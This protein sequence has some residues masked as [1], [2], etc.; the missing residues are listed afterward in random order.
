MNQQRMKQ[1]IMNQL[2]MN[3]ALIA[4]W[5]SFSSQEKRIL[6]T[7]AVVTLCLIFY[8]FAW[9]PVQHGRERLAKV[10]PEQQAKLLL[11]R[12]QAA[13]IERLRSLYKA[14]GASTGALKA[15]IQVSAKMQGL[16]PSYNEASASNISAKNADKQLAI[17]L[18]QVSFDSWLKWVES[19][20]SQNHVRVVSCRITPTGIAGQVKVEA[21]FSAAE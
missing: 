7:L 15:A 4:R 17:T 11:M 6:S 12:T 20:Q 8:A 5:N 18:T 16:T 1:F 3:Q 19:L 21:V 14:L 2:P 9:L 10:I 13:D